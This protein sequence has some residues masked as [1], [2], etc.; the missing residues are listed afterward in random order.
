MENVLFNNSLTK[1][2]FLGLSPQLTKNDEKEILASLF[3]QLLLF[4]KI[5]LSTDKNNR[6]LIFLISKL[7]LKTVESL[8]RSGYINFSIKSAII[9]S[10]TGRQRKDGTID[11]SVIYKQPPI[12]GASLL[13]DD[14]DPSENIYRA[15]KPFGINKR[16][17]KRLI[18]LITPKYIQNEGLEIGG[19]TAKVVTDAY[20]NNNLEQLG[21]PFDKDL[22]DLDLK[23]RKILMELGY[24]Y[25]ILQS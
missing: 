1:S 17:R 22:F 18:K 6:T 20:L 2:S 11:K 23:E 15:L 16:E 4:D 13:G 10:G 14:I 7:G 24:K 3:E 21:L 8:I 19:N 25:L 9:I 12:S 5:V